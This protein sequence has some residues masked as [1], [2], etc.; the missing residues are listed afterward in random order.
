MK[1]FYRLSTIHFYIILKLRAARNEDN[2][3]LST[4]HFYIIL[5][6]EKLKADLIRGLSTIHFYIILKR[7]CDG[8]CC[9]G[10]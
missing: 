6:H 9:P 8:D 2:L 1:T 4:I 7:S 3:G 10:V 5:K